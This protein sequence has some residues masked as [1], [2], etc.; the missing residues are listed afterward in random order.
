MKAGAARIA[1]ASRS[2]K[3]LEVTKQE[4]L[5]ISPSVKVLI[6]PTDITSEDGVCHL[7]AAVK[8]EFG[9]PDVLVNGAGLWSSVET[10]GESK[11][12]EW[13]RDFVRHLTHA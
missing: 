8:S 10:I 7:E 4:L 12:S 11:P 9:I 5:D 2:S 6:V 1:I 13:W 3:N